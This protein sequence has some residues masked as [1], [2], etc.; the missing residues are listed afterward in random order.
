MKQKIV[1]RK[2]TG[3]VGIVLD[4]RLEKIKYNKAMKVEYW[5]KVSYKNLQKPIW[6]SR[7]EVNILF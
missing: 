2:M 5:F 4:R 1:E 6:V 7:R 3:D